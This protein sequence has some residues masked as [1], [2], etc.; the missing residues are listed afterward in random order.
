MTTRSFSSLKGDV[1]LKHMLKEKP[2]NNGGQTINKHAAYRG[3]GGKAVF[4]KTQW[5]PL[6]FHSKSDEND[7]TRR[8]ET[9]RSTG[10]GLSMG[11]CATEIFCWQRGLHKQPVAGGWRMGAVRCG[12]PASS[13]SH[14]CLLPSSRHLCCAIVRSVLCFSFAGFIEIIILIIG[15]K[16]Q[17]RK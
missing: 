13:H 10:S 3:V 6:L 11:V 8:D 14:S 17:R 9:R 7:E 15:N 5:R 12:S 4:R 1:C 16:Q 2:L